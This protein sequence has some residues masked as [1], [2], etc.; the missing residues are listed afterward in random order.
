MLVA[1]IAVIAVAV[2]AMAVMSTQQQESDQGIDDSVSLEDTRLKIYGNADGS[3]RLDETDLKV[4]K[5]IIAVNGDS[6]AT[7]DIDWEK[8]YP[9]A[10]ANYDGTVDQKDAD[11]V[12]TF[13]D[14]GSSRM[15]Y[16]NFYGNVTYVNY[17]IGQKVG[18]E[19]LNLTL[20]SAIGCYDMLKAVDATTPGMYANLYPGVD[21]MPILGTWH[22]LT[23]E[24]INALYMDGTIDTL[25]QWTGGQNT[26]YIWDKAE[27]SGLADK[28]SIVIVP[29][30]GPRVI[31]GVL[32]LACMLGDQTLSDKYRAWYDEAMVLMD[33]IAE[34]AEK[35]TV[36]VIRCYNTK[37]STIAAFGS[38]QGPALWFNEIVNF[39]EPYVGKT[40]FV[41]LGSVESFVDSATDEVIVMFQKSCA[42]DEFN[43][44]VEE[45]LGALYKETTQFKEGKMYVVDFELMPYSGGPAGCYILA[46]HLYPELFD[47]DDAIDYL[48][49]YLDNF[50]VRDGADANEGYTYTGPGYNL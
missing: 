43:D 41:T 13:L 27:R 2:A 31:E 7:N 22:E 36:T 33:S 49:E 29:C 44:L 17:P 35:K 18:S 8:E 12:Q 9:L 40:N 21:E 20:L 4:I 38:A 39:Q 50:A 11:T 32:E 47:M 6:D 14:K 37:A 1:I 25:L 28:V 24:G 42:H 16:Q 30:Q 26:D 15:Y 3:D 5:H 23:I 45:Y 48:Q 46:A 19:Y 10:D 34:K